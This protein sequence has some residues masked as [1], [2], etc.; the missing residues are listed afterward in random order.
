[1]SRQATGASTRDEI[2]D[3]AWRLFAKAKRADVRLE[4]IAREAGVSR[5]AV[6]LHFAGRAELLGSLVTHIQSRLDVQRWHRAIDEASTG[7]DAL[8]ALIR[9][10]A[11]Y[12]PRMYPFAHALDVARQSDDAAA[13]IWDERMRGR[14]ARARA[15]A[16]RIADDG[17]L[18]RGVSVAQAADQIWVMTSI[19]V[20][21]QL[22]GERR[23]S[24]AR[25]VDW[26]RRVLGATLIAPKE[27]RGDRATGG[28]PRAR[29]PR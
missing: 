23:W 11:E 10:S 24:R 3:A 7:A 21:E 5:Q 27:S 28:G 14:L 26:L 16:Q 25:Y 6:Y 8:D 29:A 22:V 17:A 9:F 13:E 18:A 19:G 15:I 4:D 1:M 12:T 2:L 20:W